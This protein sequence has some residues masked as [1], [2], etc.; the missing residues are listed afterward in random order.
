MRR[1]TACLWLLCSVSLAG[2]AGAPATFR[3]AKVLDVEAYT[4][5][6]VTGAVLK[7]NGAIV[8]IPHEMY[9]VTLGI[10]GLKVT[11]VYE[12]HWSGSF[13]ASE[14]VVGTEVP[15][16]VGDQQIV[17]TSADGTRKFK[18]KIVRRERMDAVSS[19]RGPA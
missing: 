11:A 3:P 19:T 13:R 7:G 16:A 9:R 1:I 14:L 4:D 15:C 2:A 12:A 17:V 8:S 18:A 10:D 5:R 6:Q